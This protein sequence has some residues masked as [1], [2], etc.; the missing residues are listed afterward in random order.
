M[1]RLAV[2]V[3]AAFALCALAVTLVLLLAPGLLW[4]TTVLEPL[5]S[6]EP[7]PVFTNCLEK[8][9]SEVKIQNPAYPQS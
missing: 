1:K 7:A 9:F 2:D 3:L 8:V 6:G 4:A 5:A